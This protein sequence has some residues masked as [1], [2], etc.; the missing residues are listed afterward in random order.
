MVTIL[1]FFTNDKGN[2]QENSLKN[3]I[4]SRTLLK[5]AV[6]SKYHREKHP[7]LIPKQGE[8]WKCRIVKE[9]ESGKSKGCFI[10]EP[11]EKIEESDN[12]VHLVPGLF[13][14]Q[15]INGRLIIFPKK[16]ELNW[17]LPLTHKHLMVETDGAY[18]VI[19]QLDVSKEELLE[20]EVANQNKMRRLS[21]EVNEIASAETH[22]AIATSTNE[23]TQEVVRKMRS[24]EFGKENG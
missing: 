8:M 11:F 6:I 5:I 19:V 17:I 4:I 20:L 15:S 12:V 2:K 24:P 3:E 9:T 21:A 10:V 22:M 14:K 1:K 7:D 23:I 18:C 13:Y 16:P